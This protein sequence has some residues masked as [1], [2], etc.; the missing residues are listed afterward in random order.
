MANSDH[1]EI[2]C[3]GPKVWN[4]WRDENPQIIP[5]L[6]K[7]NVALSE[8]QFGPSEGGPI[9]LR[10][11]NLEGANLRFTTLTEADLEGA[12]LVG[13][14]LLHAKL[15]R[16]K[17]IATDL[18]D[19]M[20]DHADLTDARFERTVVIGTSFLNARNLT[21]AQLDGAFGDATT[22]LPDALT[23]P[24]SWFPQLEPEDDEPFRGY[25]AKEAQFEEEQDLYDILGVF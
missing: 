22:K 25:S 12:R 23:P 1:L 2:L 15:D 19:A 4:A 7:V 16:A 11:V 3:Q 24:E 21:Q 13:A 9:N 14:D 17:L 20:L 10:A 8:R 18:T 5:D 6:S